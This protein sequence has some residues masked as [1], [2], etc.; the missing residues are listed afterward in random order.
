MFRGYKKDSASAMPTKP[1]N[2][3]T[4][5]QKLYTAFIDN[6]QASIDNHIQTNTFRVIYFLLT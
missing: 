6:H 2:E 1:F 4:Y 3:K 5:Q